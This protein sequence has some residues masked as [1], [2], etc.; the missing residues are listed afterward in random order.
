MRE[1]I[2][3]GRLGLEEA[4]WRAEDHRALGTG[5]QEILLKEEA[6]RRL[7]AITSTQVKAI[8]GTEYQQVGALIV[9]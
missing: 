5:S 6:S 4:G 2:G 8:L 7:A 9:K 1:T 3:D